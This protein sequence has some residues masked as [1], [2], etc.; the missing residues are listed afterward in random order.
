MRVS[1]GSRAKACKV[2]SFVCIPGCILV[3]SRK[4]GNC[5]LNVPVSITVSISVLSQRT[6]IAQ[7]TSP[8]L[9][10]KAAAP[11]VGGGAG[12]ERS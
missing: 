10:R 9:L 5:T 12:R 7:E 6:G 2:K 11:D 8:F 1:S 4:N 3:S